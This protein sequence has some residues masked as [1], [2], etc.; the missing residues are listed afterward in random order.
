[1]KKKLIKNC[2]CCSKKLKIPHHLTKYC[3]NCALHT[4]KLRERISGTEVQLRNLKIKLYGDEN[5]NL[6]NRKNGK[7]LNT[8]S[9]NK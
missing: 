5:G 6:N 2:E 3:G 9:I 4:H 1:M 8:S 7:Y